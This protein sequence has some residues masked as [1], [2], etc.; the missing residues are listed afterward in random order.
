MPLEQEIKTKYKQLYEAKVRELTGGASVAGDGDAV[1]AAI[2]REAQKYAIAETA[3]QSFK[4]GGA[5]KHLMWNWIYEAH[6]SRKSGVDVDASAIPKVISADQSW[7]K[8][9][10]HAFESM[11]KDLC[12]D[13]LEGTGILVVLQKDAKKMIDHGEIINEGPDFTWLKPLISSSVFDLFAVKDKKIFCCIQAKTSIRDRVTRDREPSQN[14]MKN[15]FWS[16]VFA[17]DG[18]F[19]ALPKF[20]H[21]VNGGNDEF[22]ENGWHGMYAFS[23]PGSEPNDRIYLLDN[24]LSCFKEHAVQAATDWTERRQWF[25]HDWRPGQE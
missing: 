10:G 11:V 12:N 19:L 5:D 4:T 14:A 7:K 2:E 24:H 22:R 21:M 25:N 6:V 15:F 13:A 1:N 16:V 17:L 18:S 9:S 23:L 20:K 8:S 3:L